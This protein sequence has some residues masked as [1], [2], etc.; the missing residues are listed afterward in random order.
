[1]YVAR[2]TPTPKA[3]PTPT[4]ESKQNKKESPAATPNGSAPKAPD[5]TKQPTPPETSGA[6]FGLLI[7]LGI[8]GAVM[9]VVGLIALGVR[10]GWATSIPEEEVDRLIE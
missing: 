10:Y 8:L 1:M 6:P 9:M 4:G 2:P 5:Q 7:G 3:T